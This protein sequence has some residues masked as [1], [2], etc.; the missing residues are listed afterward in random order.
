MWETDEKW[1]RDTAEGPVMSR[2]SPTIRAVLSE[3][4]RISWTP[5]MEKHTEECSWWLT[6]QSADGMWESTHA[7]LPTPAPAWLSGAVD[8]CRQRRFGS[9]WEGREWAG[10]SGLSCPPDHSK[11]S[12]V[13]PIVKEQRERQKREDPSCFWGLTLSFSSLYTQMRNS[14]LFRSPS[15]RNIMN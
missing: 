12:L 1:T 10:A 5:H 15:Q 6:S 13:Q 8:L 4:N 7:W 2:T 3:R 11:T 9:R 14:S